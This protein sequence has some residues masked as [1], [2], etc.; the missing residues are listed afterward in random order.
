MICSD[1]EG[2]IR[3]Q[4]RQVVQ[5]KELSLRLYSWDGK[6]KI[7]QISAESVEI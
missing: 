2:E 6:T 7:R 3:L 1:R 4:T 5:D